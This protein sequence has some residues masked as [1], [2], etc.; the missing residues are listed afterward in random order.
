MLH[1]GSLPRDARSRISLRSDAT[2][3]VT[4]RVKGSC[5][6]P[7][8]QRPPSPWS[9]SGAGRHCLRLRPRRRGYAVRPRAPAGTALDGR[10]RAARA[11]RR[12]VGGSSSPTSSTLTAPRNEPAALELGGSARALL[13]VV[14]LARRSVDRGPRPPEPRVPRRQLARDVGPDARRDRAA[15]CSTRSRR[16]SPRPAPT[17]STATR[18]A[19]VHDLYAF[20]VDQLAR[21]RA[22]RDGHA[23]RRRRCG[24]AAPARSSCSSPGLTGGRVGAARATPATQRSSAASR[25]GSTTASRTARRRRGR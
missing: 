4:P 7:T 21:A 25:H 8:K 20:A 12:R 13:A 17:P 9:S 3:A 19:A 22:A 2:S 1:R 16:R 24:A 23:A 14:R 10:S 18:D 15:G 6:H 11:Q 5:H